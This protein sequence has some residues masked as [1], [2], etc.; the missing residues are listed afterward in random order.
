MPIV[1]IAFLAGRTLDQ[2]RC[3]AEKVTA[4]VAESLDC[5]PD[6]VRIIFREMKEEDFARGGKLALDW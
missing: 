6:A 2:K 1:Q 3:L 4:A 5:P